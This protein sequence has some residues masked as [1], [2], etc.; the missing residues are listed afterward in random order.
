[1]TNKELLDSL[2]GYEGVSRAE[3]PVVENLNTRILAAVESGAG[4]L[5]MSDWHTCET[6][7][8]RAG[9][10]IVLAGEAGRRL[11]RVCG[12]F[13][14][15]MLITLASCPWMDTRPDFYADNEDALAEIKACAAREKEK[16]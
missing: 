3:V 5:D 11:E 16:P 14:A 2:L 15:G 10:A 13:E 7:H 9:W 12:S 4:R 1:M 6:T 8:C